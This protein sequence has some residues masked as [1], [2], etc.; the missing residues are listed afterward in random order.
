MTHI[1]VIDNDPDARTLLAGTLL[2]SG[3]QM[4]DAAAAHGCKRLNQ[5]PS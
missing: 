2:S 3:A 1:L 4:T 5:F